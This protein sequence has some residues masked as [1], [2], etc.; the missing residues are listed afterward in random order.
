MLGRA[1]MKI[2][3]LSHPMFFA[4]T[5][6]IVAVAIT[7]LYLWNT[8]YASP[9]L[10]YADDGNPIIGNLDGFFYLATAQEYL[11]GN[12]NVPA[13]A[14]FTA[15]LHNFT[16]IELTNIAFVLPAIFS[17]L[18]CV[19]YYFWGKLLNF[20][21]I[22]T[23]CA[24]FFGSFMPAWLERSRMGWFDTDTGIAL[25]WNICLIA[26]A[27]VSLPRRKVEIKPHEKIMAWFALFTSGLLLAWWWKPGAVLLPLCIG[28]WG[29][30]FVWAGNT[31]EKRLR[32]V[33]LALLVLSTIIFAIMPNNIAP[34]IANLRAY[35]LDHMQLVL[36]LKNDILLSSSIIELNSLSIWEGLEQLGGHWLGGV[37]LI[38]ALICF[39]IH[40]PS[41]FIVFLPSVGALILG[42]FAERFLYIAALPLGLAVASF[43]Q[44]INQWLKITHKKYY[45]LGLISYTLLI[46]IC[47]GQW[48]WQ[49]QP[50]IYFQKEHDAI[51]L[52]LRNDANSKAPVWN[53]WDD[54]YFLYARAR[55][56]PLFDGGSQNAFTAHIASRPFMTENTLFA[57]RWIR[58]FSLR[59]V[60]AINPLIKHYGSEDVAWQKLERI[61]MSNNLQEESLPP[62]LH[63]WLFPQG[64]VYI[65]FSQRILKLSRWW[66]SLGLKRHAQAQ[67]LRPYLD[68][69]EREDFY[70]NR[71]KKLLIL[72]QKVIDNSYTGVHA[73]YGDA[74]NPLTPPFPQTEGIF[75]IIPPEQKWV[76][77]ATKDGLSSLPL[78]LMASNVEIQGFKPIAIDYDYAGAWEVLP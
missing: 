67:D 28:L 45:Y 77:F 33:V 75:A 16:G 19:C 22:M 36:G 23:F 35:A 29:L 56:K 72:P 49:W 61:F 65:Y 15:N 78:R 13:L 60:N 12:V 30:T 38:I 43:G 31:I 9:S 68:V 66:G 74:D 1:V 52:A 2:P 51:A 27:Y 20:S 39:A 10:F 5:G 24:A 62:S 76:Y 58:F 64:K 44:N 26:T 48:I 41:V 3:N 59:G 32:Q 8:L 50:K 11:Q 25:F 69:Y 6:V 42:F 63:A 71:A 34:S 21:P 7:N 37:L 18:L 40:S 47:F 55:L 73:V 4:M 46:A 14:W 17:F 57:R 70:Y 54:G 53:W